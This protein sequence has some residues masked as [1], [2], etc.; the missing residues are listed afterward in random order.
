MSRYI[1][2]QDF[3]RKHDVTPSNLYVRKS[4]G[5]IPGSAFKKI[6]GNASLIDEEFFEKRKLFKRK[7][8]LE[9]HDYYYFLTMY[10]TDSDLAW[11]LHR[12][13]GS[14]SIDSWT[15]FIC[16]RLF[17]EQDDDITDYRVSRLFYAFYRYSR[18]LIRGIFIRGQ[19][20][21]WKRDIYVLLDKY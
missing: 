15:S 7:V 3:C 17:S 6:P 14:I 1:L 11:W 2:I 12:V 9:C 5:T 20:P 10:S 8:W 13:D 4:L 19:M 21:R 18:W 16:N